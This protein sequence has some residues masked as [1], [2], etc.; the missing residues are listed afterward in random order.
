MKN[1]AKDYKTKVK[2]R[3]RIHA[4]SKTSHLKQS[5]LYKKKYRGQGK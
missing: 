4:K 1:N 2:K 5:K 3:K